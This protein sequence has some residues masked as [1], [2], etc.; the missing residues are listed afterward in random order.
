[1]V[2]AAT[3]VAELGD[4]TRFTN[5]RQL[6]AYLGLVPSEHSSGKTRRQGGITRQANPRHRMEGAGTT[7]PA[8]SQTRPGWEARDARDRGDRA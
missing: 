8:V 7:L 5:P 2:S 4:I 1:M 3:L 6:M